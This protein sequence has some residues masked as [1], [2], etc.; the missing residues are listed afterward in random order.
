MN[1]S[2]QK[3]DNNGTVTETITQE[4]CTVTLNLQRDTRC[5]KAMIKF[6]S[7]LNSSSATVESLYVEKY[8]DRFLSSYFGTSEQFFTKPSML[9]LDSTKQ[10][11]NI[12][13]DIVSSNGVLGA[14]D[15][16]Y[17]AYSG[18]DTVRGTVNLGESS[19]KI[20]APHRVKNHLV[21]D[22]PTHASNGTIDK[23]V[24]NDKALYSTSASYQPSNRKRTPLMM[25][26]LDSL[27]CNE[28]S[29]L[30][31]HL[32]NG[33]M[34]VNNNGDYIALFYI[35]SSANRS[36]I[37]KD[38]KMY[39]INT[40]NLIKDNKYSLYIT[41][42]NDTFYLH[43]D[44]SDRTTINSSGL[45]LY[46]LNIDV[47]DGEISVT[48]DDNDFITIPG[49]SYD[50]STKVY[51]NFAIQHKD[52]IL[53]STTRTSDNETKIDEFDLNFNYIKTV[54][55]FINSAS[56][57]EYFTYNSNFLFN[58]EDELIHTKGS[59]N[60]NKGS[61][62]YTNS[63]YSLINK[64]YIMCCSSADCSH[65]VGVV[66]ENYNKHHSSQSNANVGTGNNNIIGEIEV[67]PSEIVIDLKQPIV[68]TDVETLKLIFD[69]EFE[70]E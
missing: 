30:S 62:S 48:R 29:S 64:N 44:S 26:R 19:I 59:Y 60:F 37:R 68:K 43:S 10:K 4:D 18:N 6:L 35:S 8:S 21:I 31:P 25:T 51:F 28:C 36:I 14:C 15:C 42:I 46:K 3:I 2:I 66:N 45:K 34:A 57:A 47:V 7:M 38:G 9:L 17:E 65:S 41:C 1:F 50:T 49:R 27:Y 16:R 22:F 12:T 20:E 13:S 55:T 58:G 24:F 70:I 54:E 63:V 11:T 56:Y 23:I 32:S 52:K 61:Y 33:T 40:S 39:K 53:V 67:K 69:F 5:A